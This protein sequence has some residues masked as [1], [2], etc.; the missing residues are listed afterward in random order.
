VPTATAL[1]STTQAASTAY[2]DAATGVEKTRALAAEALL[3]PLASPA[4]TGTPTAP[5]A[6]AATSTT[7]VATTAFVGTAVA[8]ANVVDGVTVSGTPTSGQSI[9][10]TSGTAATWQTPSGSSA[11]VNSLGFG[12]CPVASP[13]A[14]T[15]PWPMAGASTSP[16]SG[17]LNGMPVA[18]AAG[19]VVSNISFFTVVAAVTPTNWW[20]GLFRWNSGT[21]MQMAH[22]ADQ[23]TTP[24]AAAT[25][26]TLPMVTPY[27]IPSTGTDT[28]Y[29]AAE[30]TFASGLTLATSSYVGAPY[31]G[32]PGGPAKYQGFHVS[33]YTA[34]PGTDGVTTAA[35]GSIGSNI[36]AWMCAS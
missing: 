34:G 10:A 26:H 3:A 13:V 1:T 14:Q 15:Y 21:P 28:Y 30:F 16:L 11:P 5:T 36:G 31:W 19:Q 20:A 7:Q 29:L 17:W 35:S 23:T 27:T 4:L 8:A 33:T 12:Y 18:L 9:V 2:A 32:P 24:I 22:S 25:L 6:T